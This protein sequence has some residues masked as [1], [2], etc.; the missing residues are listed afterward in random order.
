M[1]KPFY[2]PDDPEM[3]HI[4]STE[5]LAWLLQD[6]GNWRAVGDSS[7]RLT[8]EDTLRYVRELYVAGAVEVMATDI[9]VDCDVESG[10]YL[11][12]M[13]PADLPTRAALLAIQARILNETGSCF[14]ADT[15]RGQS[16][17]TIGW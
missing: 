16:F 7:E 4:A 12:V 10:D 1:S 14:D 6:D 8:P 5:A 2:A 9:E 17:F 3:Y 13:L 15:E 11:H